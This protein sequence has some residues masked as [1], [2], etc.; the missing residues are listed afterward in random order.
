MKRVFIAIGSNKGNRE[1]N[2]IKSIK[3]MEKIGEIKKISSFYEN[4][5]VNADGGYFL[6]GV[7]E[8]ITRFGPF[9]LLKKLKEIEK[10]IGRKFPHK[11]GDERE[12]D[13]DIIFYGKELLKTK[14]LEVPHKEFKKREFVLRGLLE[15]ASNFRDPITNKRVKEIYKELKNEN[16]EK[17]K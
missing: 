16:I 7:I 3:E 11:K 2:I 14:I 6:N 5:P 13:L 10:K 8:I 17:D 9:L 15:I 1:E 4:E 12:I